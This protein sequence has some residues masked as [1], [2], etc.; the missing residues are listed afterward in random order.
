M[1][2]AG[3]AE[4]VFVV[5][6]K[7]STQTL[8]ARHVRDVIVVEDRVLAATASGLHT[9]DDGGQTW[10]EPQLEGYEVWQVRA[11]SNGW[12][13][14]G[15]QPTGLFRSEDHG[16]TWT[17]LSSF[18]ALP[19]AAEWCVPLDPP[20]PG[21]AR[22]IVIDEND[23]D[24]IWVGVEVGGVARTVDGGE[25]WTV[26]LP[27]GNP[28][29]HMLYA[30]PNEPRTLFATTG[31]G[32]FDHIAEEVEGNA[33]VFRSDDHGETWQYAWKG[34]T[35]RYSRP[36]CID[37]RA[38]YSLTVASAP[39]AFSSHKN[40]GGANAALFRSDD[41]GESWRSLCDD[42]HSPSHANFHGLTTDPD[43]LG[44]VLVGTDTGELWRVSDDSHWEEL[45]TG[46]PLVWSLATVDQ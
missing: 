21:R 23:P 20:L 26:D 46:L 7:G 31:Y 33:G 25:T 30:H 14:A 19:E 28:D 5:D 35:P 37:R 44:G 2:L 39:T 4:G 1:L 18:A 22:A 6:D 40:D 10:S 8:E 34:I 29:L 15:T 27:G 32:R 24:R 11:A 42:A 9:S 45:A 16:E 3:T 17:E 38:P 36:M 43:R 13:Y 41:H 12:I